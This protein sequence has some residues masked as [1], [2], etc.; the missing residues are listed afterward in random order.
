MDSGGRGGT[1]QQEGEGTGN[2]PRIGG[3]TT[4]FAPEYGSKEVKKK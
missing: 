2:A 1:I 3:R 4:V